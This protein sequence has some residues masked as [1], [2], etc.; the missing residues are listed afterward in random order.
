MEHID[1]ATPAPIKTE[2]SDPNVSTTEIKLEKTAFR[3]PAAEIKRDEISMEHSNSTIPAPVNMERTNST[4]PNAEINSDEIDI[5][6]SSPTTPAPSPVDMTNTNSNILA[7]EIKMEKT[8]STASTLDMKMKDIN[9]EHEVSNPPAF[10]ISTYQAG[11]KV[12]AVEIK[13][14]NR[15]PTAPVSHI[16]DI[17][18]QR[19]GLKGF[20]ELTSGDKIGVTTTEHKDS[21]APATINMEYTEPFT[22][23][24]INMA[25]TKSNIPA[26]EIKLEKTATT[27]LAQEINIEDL[28]NMH[29]VPSATKRRR[30][31][32]KDPITP[33]ADF[34]VKNHADSTEAAGA[35]S[36]DE[37]NVNPTE[38]TA[39][40]AETKMNDTDSLTLAAELKVENSSLIPPI[41]D[42][43][44]EETNPSVPDSSLGYE[45]S[46]EDIQDEASL[47]SNAI[48]KSWE[49][50]QS[51]LDLHQDTI[52]ARWIKKS[53]ASRKELLMEVWPGI[54]RKHRPDFAIFEKE[55]PEKPLRHVITDPE[56]LSAAKW[57]N[58]NLEDLS[59]G[60]YL[61]ILMEARARCFPKV[62]AR[63]D[64]EA[65]LVNSAV[66]SFSTATC[67]GHSMSLSGDNNDSYGKVLRLEGNQSAQD[68]LKYGIDFDIFKGLLIL[69]IQQKL[70]Q[71]LES[72]CET[73]LHDKKLPET[74]QSR[75][76]INELN[77]SAPYYAPGSFDFRSLMLLLATQLTEAIGVPIY[78]NPW[79]CV[80][81]SIESV[82][83]EHGQSDTKYGT[84]N[85]WELCA[86]NVSE[87]AYSRVIMAEICLHLATDMHRAFGDWPQV[88]QLPS[89][90]PDH[91]RLL[92][93]MLVL[94]HIIDVQYDLPSPERPDK[95][96]SLLQAFGFFDREIESQM[97][98]QKLLAEIESVLESNPDEKIR[99][100]P[101]TQMMLGKVGFGLRAI[102]TIDLVS[103]S[104]PVS[105]AR[106]LD[107]NG[108]ELSKLDELVR[109]E[110]AT[111][112][113]FK[114]DFRGMS[115]DGFGSPESGRFNYPCWKTRTPETI[116]QMCR[117]ERCLG[118][119]WDKI[120]RSF[121]R[122][123]GKSIHD[124]EPPIFKDRQKLRTRE[125]MKMFSTPSSAPPGH[126][127]WNDFLNAMSDS[128]FNITKQYA[129][130]GAFSYTSH[131]STRLGL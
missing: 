10:D 121:H 64:L 102:Q 111:H 65:S 117:A 76:S 82:C 2:H 89:E 36:K 20:L 106:I 41:G 6:H 48:F 7:I 60:R 26:V 33:P 104:V 42:I 70:L 129:F 5:R 24:P 128:G 30:K 84:R 23:T 1:S 38:S 87:E 103:P 63:P 81:S 131:R 97:G 101:I 44:K 54:P 108:E 57:P 16:D 49:K 118:E 28:D 86:V 58:F 120:D 125:P 105:W 39:P 95:L 93:Q 112:T 114:D 98:R 3:A 100:S 116:R 96:M 68:R 66:G 61:L 31:V 85:H 80:E 75:T 119:Y 130:L 21:T 78:S 109:P 50:L 4:T 127:K 99:L 11:S 59:K 13:T 15:Y 73:I 79:E 122:S 40:A 115:Y 107:E 126:I 14:E 69:E 124:L 113:Q 53:G 34:E 25:N 94:R 27:V 91:Q 18:I 72:C 45:R 12:L 56:E 51:L 32:D 46:P 19:T 123:C 67:S 90:S 55:P 37:I 43:K 74:I 47:R 88:G 62:F 29:S 8:A 83:D 22:P 52:N 9:M 92:D 77:K 17:V 35:G 71:F 110:L